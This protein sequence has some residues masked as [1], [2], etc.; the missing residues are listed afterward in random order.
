MKDILKGSAVIFGFKV[1]GAVALFLIHILISRY[2]GAETLGI[3]NLILSIM[4]ISAIFSRVGLDMYVVRI[5]PSL[6]NDNN[7]IALFLKEVFKII[8]IGGAIVTIVFYFLSPYINNYIFKSFDASKY[9]LWLI[10]IIIPFS[11]YDILSELLRAFNEIRL[12]SFFKNF[13]QNFLLCSI[14]FISIFFLHKLDILYTLYFIIFIITL[15]I[16]FVI[17]KIFKKKN[18]NIFN[19]GK[20]SK[21]ILKYSYPMFFTSSILF[22]MGN[23][24]SFMI[25][26]YLNERNVGIYSACIKLS[27]LITFILASI[28]GFI[29]PKISEAYGKKN[30]NVLKKIYKDS[31]I[32][33]IIVTLPIFIIL[34]IFPEF[35]LGLF[36]EEFKDFKNTLIIMIIGYL[37]NAFLGPVGYFLNMTDNQKVFMKIL[38]IGLITNIILNV[39]LIPIYQLN[40]AAIATLISMSLWNLISFYTLKKKKII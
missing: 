8:F 7:Q 39:I 36:G 15:G 28:N 29:A 16:F 19:Q 35:F 33:I 18:I 3:F 23:I 9:L 22:F 10:F 1:F 40:G 26:Y 20:Y 13:L 30:Y 32:L 6:G 2:Y 21:N 14:L 37:I 4:M 38:L 11:L 27:F 25:S 5:I 17:I 34:F 31:T 12:Y 24:D